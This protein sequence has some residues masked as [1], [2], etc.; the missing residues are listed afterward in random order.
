MTAQDHVDGQV[1][2]SCLPPPGAVFALGVS[3][4][5]CVATDRAGN[6]VA[7][8]F[9]VTVADTTAPTITAPTDP[10]VEATSPEGADVT[11]GPIEATDA[12][13]D[14]VIA[15]CDPAPG[16]FSVGDTSV[17]CT[18]SD[19][20]GNDAQATFAVHVVDTTPPS[21]TVTG[22]QTLEATGPEGAMAAPFSAI[23]VDLVDGELPVTC[24]EPPDQ[25]FALGTTE[26]VCS[27]TDHAGK[28]AKASIFITV[29]DTTPPALDLPEGHSAEA[30][31]PDGA[32]VFFAVF[33]EDVVDGGLG[34][35]CDRSSGDTFPLGNSTVVCHASDAR[36]NTATRSF[37]VVVQD[38]TG[39][40]IA[41]RRI[42]AEPLEATGPEGAPLRY[43]ASAIDAVGGPVDVVCEPTHSAPRRSC[44]TH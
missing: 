4:V 12:V 1:P 7:V 15:T 25:V 42:S 33:A 17:T 11:Y 16:R 44:V 9:D 31:G 10:V 3:T 37:P 38:T 36:G 26:V 29:Q 13:D 20:A 2:T 34:V 43:S 21:I 30:T 6:D 27:A 24:S 41:I 5:G 22:D 35:T 18:M 28:T 39:P 19:R 8:R 23:A 32:P 40:V 14:L